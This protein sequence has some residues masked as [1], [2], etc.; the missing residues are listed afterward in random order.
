MSEKAQLII[1]TLHTVK[2]LTLI[3]HTKWQD[4]KIYLILRAWCK[5]CSDKS[6]CCMKL[7][8]GINR[9]LLINYNLHQ[10]VSGILYP[11]YMLTMCI[12]TFSQ[13]YLRQIR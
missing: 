4:T 12:Y 10:A 5:L 7:R 2:Q 3:L 8:V 1:I 9:D 6:Y 13:M 11:D